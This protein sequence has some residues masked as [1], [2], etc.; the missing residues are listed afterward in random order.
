[1]N[2]NLDVSRDVILDLAP[3]YLSGDASAE[4]R[5]LVDGYLAHDHE[6]AVWMR[7]QKQTVFA[8]LDEA[9]SQ[10][11]G[12][13]ALRR[14]RRRLAV[15]RWF[16]GIALFFAALSLTSEY[17]TSRG[18]FVEF[19]FLARDHPLAAAF[20]IAS[21]VGCF[22]VYLTLRR[23]AFV[24]ALVLAA[25]G[26]AS[27]NSWA[28]AQG[29]REFRID[30]GHSTIEFEVLF[31][32]SH[33]RG[34]FDDVRGWLVL[35]DSAHGG[36]SASAVAAVIRSASINTG[37]AHR[38]EHLRSS[39]FFDAARFPAITFHTER[40][41]TADDGFVL[42]GPLTM[43]G[44]THVVRVRCRLTVPPVHDPHHVVIAVVTGSTTLARRDFGILGGSVHNAWFDELRSATMGDSVRVSL[45]M[46]FW[47]PDADDP[48]PAVRA[49]IARLDSIGIDS[50]IARLRAAF[51]RDSSAVAASEYSLDLIG[52]TLLARG[53]VKEGFLWLHAL[54]RLLTRSADAMAAVGY[55]NEIM[56]D[57]ARAGIWYRQALA[58]DS[59]NPR[60]T[61]RLMRIS[62]D[63]G[64]A[65]PAS[66]QTRERV[67]SLSATFGATKALTV[68]K[69]CLEPEVSHE[70]TSRRRHPLGICTE[71]P[72]AGPGSAGR[73]SGCH[74][75]WYADT[76]LDKLARD[77][78]AHRCRR[79]RGKR[80][81]SHRARLSG[82]HNTGGRSLLGAGTR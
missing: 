8:P 81:V 20:C 35:A 30:T 33:V 43:H 1:M 70:R 51:A 32:Y 79:H 13:T 46:H 50:A 5:A 23:R 28:K 82:I 69:N 47:A 7:E 75:G 52:E 14:A 65:K 22:S 49:S 60:A 16:F 67:S 48:E 71:Y 78:E 64:D 77:V 61:V 19:H 39:D 37:S 27:P 17:S 56:G 21:A 25:V 58:A 54:A 4:T 80:L 9:P 63:A 15:Q 73:E 10:Q 36:L 26:L 41:E 57:R 42:V 44:A 40:V 18:R 68:A 66:R 55:S 11:T 31:A 76:G 6:L 34:R 3:L 74:S 62:R 29:D 2:V 59:L 24:W 45:E 53:R 12:L 38:D 72:F